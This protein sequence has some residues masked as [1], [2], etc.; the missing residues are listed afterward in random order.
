M[1]L[2]VCSFII[3]RSIIIIIIYVY[4]II[5]EK[6]QKTVLTNINRNDLKP[7][8]TV[9]ALSSKRQNQV[10][11]HHSAAALHRSLERDMHAHIAQSFNMQPITFFVTLKNIILFHSK[12]HLNIYK[13]NIVEF[14]V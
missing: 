5:I 10:H 13:L 2:V 1:M 14:I 9:S 11:F 8:G 7:S 3:D 6:T 4:L 12:L